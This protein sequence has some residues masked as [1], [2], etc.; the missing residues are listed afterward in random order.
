MSVKRRL[1]LASQSPRRSELLARAGFEF[2]LSPSQISE[3]PDENLNLTDQIQDLARRKA[4]A[5]LN[6]G[7]LVKGQGNLILS[8]DTVVVLDGQILGKP[9]DRLENE[10][11]LRR[12]SGQ[13]HGVITAICLLDV[14]TG[15]RA[16]GHEISQITFKDLND[17]QIMEYADT[18]EGLDKAGGY[19]IQGAAGA[20]VRTVDGPYDNVVGLPVE[21]L[22]K[23]LRENGWNVDRRESASGQ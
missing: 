4:E 5:C 18:E 1:V 11:Y 10:Q 14:D 8:A 7:K 3:I 22:K 21:L 19:G 16:L 17:C 13:T 15:H 9:Q 6:S 20:F 23:L 12:L 2:A